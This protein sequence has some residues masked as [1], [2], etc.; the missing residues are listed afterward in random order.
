MTT[1][2]TLPHK[3]D[4]LFVVSLP[5]PKP[6]CTLRILILPRIHLGRGFPASIRQ[7]R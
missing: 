6:L 2:R 4:E 5:P 7:Y 1:G 3:S